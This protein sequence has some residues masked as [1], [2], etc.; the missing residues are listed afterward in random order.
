MSAQRI[1]H[2]MHRRLVDDGFRT[3]VG[4]ELKRFGPLDFELASGF[5]KFVFYHDGG[6]VEVLYEDIDAAIERGD[7]AAARQ[8]A[9]DAVRKLREVT[10]S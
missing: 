7:Y 10:P 6:M 3:T 4:E 1:T 2:S 8:L 9:K 5:D